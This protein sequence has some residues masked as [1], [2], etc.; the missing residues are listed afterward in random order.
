M[1]CASAPCLRPPSPPVLRQT[2]PLAKLR[3]RRD[4]VPGHR[5]ALTGAG[6]QPPALLLTPDVSG[7]GAHRRVVRRAIFREQ[8]DGLT[9]SHWAGGVFRVREVQHGASRAAPPREREM[10]EPQFFR[11]GVKTSAHPLPCDRRLPHRCQCG[12]RALHA[13]VRTSRLLPA[14][15]GRPTG[16]GGCGR[17]PVFSESRRQARTGDGTARVETATRAPRRQPRCGAD[18]ESVGCG[19]ASCPHATA[20]GVGVRCPRPFARCD[21]FPAAGSGD[22]VGL[23]RPSGAAE[24]RGRRG[25][26]APSRATCPSGSSRGAW[27]HGRLSPSCSRLHD[28]LARFLFEKYQCDLGLLNRVLDVYQPVADRIA[29]A[30]AFTCVDERARQRSAAAIQR[31]RSSWPGWRSPT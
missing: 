31:S 20:Q 2:R 16:S 14:G 23:R 15:R 3:G 25:V 21:V 12:H 7:S 19:P 5:H 4:G 27:S 18:A 26:A 24:D 30:V 6:R 28:V 29:T 13:A 11:A 17:T 22:D 9:S 10:Q 1:I 8:A